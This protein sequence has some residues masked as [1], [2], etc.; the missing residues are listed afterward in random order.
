MLRKNKISLI[1]YYVVKEAI[2]SWREDS[3]YVRSV[4]K[5]I[6]PQCV[7]EKKFKKKTSHSQSDWFIDLFILLLHK[8][9]SP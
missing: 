9:P 2:L 7:G 5:N 3:F 8:V 1:N 4:Y 6:S